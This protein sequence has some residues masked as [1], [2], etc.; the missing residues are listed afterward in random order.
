M[1][2]LLYR[3]KSAFS[4]CQIGKVVLFRPFV[5]FGP[6][7]PSLRPLSVLSCLRSKTLLPSFEVSLPPLED[8]LLRSKSLFLR[9][10]TLDSAQARNCFGAVFFF[11]A[12]F[13]PFGFASSFASSLRSFASLLRSFASSL[14]SFASALRLRSFLRFGFVR[15][16]F[17]RRSV[18]NRP[19]GHSLLELKKKRAN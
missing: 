12:V 15:S 18:V 3:L 2:C 5:P 14:R 6:F 19:F 9:S 4:P 17:G 13:R 11:L 10:K 1:L 16:S 7:P 8:S